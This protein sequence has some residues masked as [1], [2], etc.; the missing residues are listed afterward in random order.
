[1]EQPLSRTPKPPSS[2]DIRHLFDRIAPVYDD[3]NQQLSLGLHR[4]WKQMAI[5]WSGAST[6]Q[7]CLDICCGSGDV[8]IL[9][10]NCVGRDGQVYGLDFSEAQLAI[11]QQKTPF[12][13]H[14]A[15]LH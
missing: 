6:G 12:S 3:F 4:I 9:L 2:E 11:A 1:M 5:D 14:S 15:P 8:A 10:A 13:A 7:T